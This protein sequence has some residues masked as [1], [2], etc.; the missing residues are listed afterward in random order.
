MT[1]FAK[2]NI[3]LSTEQRKANEEATVAIVQTMGGLVGMKMRGVGFPDLSQ[4]LEADADDDL[5]GLRL[6][7]SRMVYGNDWQVDDNWRHERPLHPEVA[8][9]WLLGTDRVMDTGD[10]VLLPIETS[11][12]TLSGLAIVNSA[13][14]MRLSDAYEGITNNPMPFTKELIAEMSWHI[15]R[16]YSE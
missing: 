12:L 1:D 14:A 2:R 10:G 3:D 5:S 7:A 15:A 11:H 4:V 16:T 9:K 13:E 8:R 6:I